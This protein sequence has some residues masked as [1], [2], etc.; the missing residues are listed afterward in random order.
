MT[1]QLIGLGILPVLLAASPARATADPRLVEKLAPEISSRCSASS[2]RISAEGLRAAIGASTMAP[3]NYSYEHAGNQERALARAAFTTAGGDNADTLLLLR[4]LA[5]TWTDPSDGSSGALLPR[6]AGGIEVTYRNGAPVA[7][8]QAEAVLLAILRGDDSSFAFGCDIIPPTGGETPTTPDQDQQRRPRPVFALARDP[9]DLAI[10]D[11]KDKP[12][13]EF[14]YVRD[15]ET[16]EDSYS[17]HATAGIIWPEL[18][19]PGRERAERRPW[20]TARG[21]AVTFVQY[22]REGSSA[23]GSDEVNNLN[24]GVQLAGFLQTR[25]RDTLTHYYTLSARYLTDDRFNSSA[26]SLGATLTPQIPLPGNRVTFNI[27]PDRL[28]F[29]WLFTA[30]ADHFSVSDPGAKTE[31][32]TANEFTR[33]GF[34]LEG[35]FRLLL[36][37]PNDG[38]IALWGQYRLREAL[39]GSTGDVELLTAR[40]TFEP[41]PNVGVGLTYTRGEN[42]DSLEF[43]EQWK[44]TFG[45]RW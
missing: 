41:V 10:A 25:S 12:F 32:Q 40:L 24:F 30:A 5:E 33:V 7:R 17:I 39:G 20:L 18:F 6:S 44:F 4:R 38:A 37:G 27:V 8:D 15:E 36:G 19:G 11:L 31:L 35:Q 23:A 9:D 13:A 34:D 29:R 43:S 42:I 1:R 2:G 21:R 28:R 3:L 14:A 26:W 45:L 22:E 16:D